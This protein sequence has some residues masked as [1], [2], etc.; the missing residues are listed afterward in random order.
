MSFFNKAG[1]KKSTGL[2]RMVSAVV[3]LGVL[4]LFAAETAKYLYTARIPASVSSR[5]DPSVDKLAAVLGAAKTSLDSLY[6]AG[7][8][9]T[10]DDTTTAPATELAAKIGLFA[11]SHTNLENL[12][13]ALIQAKSMDV[14]RAVFLGDYTD[15]GEEAALADAKK[16]MDGSGVAYVS[17][18]GDHDIAETRDASNF[19]TV[20]GKTFGVWEQGGY[21]F[22]YFD[23]SRNYTAIDA[24]GITWF[25]DHIPSA[26]FLFLSQPL[27]TASMS[28][29]MGII[30]GV[31]DA[32]VYAQNEEM[33]ALV[34]AS[35]VRV[36]VAGDLHE[37]SRFVDPVRPELQHYTVGAIAAQGLKERNAYRPRFAVLTVFTDGSYTIDD[38]PIE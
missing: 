27:V 22:V 5:L 8:T 21:E 26:D 19:V 9:F 25:K 34:R 4:V 28:R 30:D 29:V 32:A 24:A 38:T 10:A 6:V 12:R 33:L 13:R 31:K 18:P 11:D 3:V 2:V 36:I 7:N 15:Y 16:V 14:A 17:L 23:N 1:T 20:F 35:T 37:F